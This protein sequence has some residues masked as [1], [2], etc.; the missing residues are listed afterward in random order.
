MKK[1]NDSK[2]KD[3]VIPYPPQIFVALFHPKK[4]TFF[5]SVIF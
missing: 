3:G 2:K 1:N 4:H 5:R